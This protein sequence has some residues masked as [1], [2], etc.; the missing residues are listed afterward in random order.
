MRTVP[1]PKG[2]EMKGSLRERQR[3]RRWKAAPF[4][5]AVLA[6]LRHAASKRRKDVAVPGVGAAAW[7]ALLQVTQTFACRK[8]RCISDGC[9]EAVGHPA[10]L[11]RPYPG[12]AM[13]A[14][15][16]PGMQYLTGGAMTATIPSPKGNEADFSLA[17]IQE[18]CL[19]KKHANWCIYHV[20]FTSLSEG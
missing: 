4:Y 16:L 11:L 13:G 15:H 12:L 6:A 9:P 17:K 1:L 20:T 7:A 18:R 5:R 14:T 3:Q 8:N 10:F 19:N 2:H